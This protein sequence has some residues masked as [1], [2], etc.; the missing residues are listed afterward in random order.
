[1]F[2]FR[3]FSVFFGEV[4][5]GQLVCNGE[6]KASL[7]TSIRGVGRNY[8][9]KLDLAKADKSVLKI[10]DVILSQVDTLPITKLTDN[11][12]NFRFRRSFQLQTSQLKQLET[13]LAAVLPVCKKL[14]LEGDAFRCDMT[15][16][17]IKDLRETIAE[18]R[19]KLTGWS[20]QP[21][22][23]M[24]RLEVTRQLAQSVDSQKD[25]EGV[26]KVIKKSLPLEL[27]YVFNDPNWRKEFCEPRD[28]NVRN[29]LGLVALQLA[30][31]EMTL[32]L[33]VADK[34]T[35]QGVYR[36]SL[37]T[38][39][40]DKEKVKYW[41]RFSPTEETRAN[42]YQSVKLHQ[43][44]KLTYNGIWHPIYGTGCLHLT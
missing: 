26:C 33:D 39:E 42:F 43:A 35:Y 17:S 32:L 41:I 5:V 15:A 6:D 14:Q 21:Y 36:L 38:P 34:E 2:S 12:K 44:E 19:K 25:I 4:K 8:R 7:E 28:E 18:Q 9:V 13:G 31:D 27:P 40:M 10:D 29:H 24:R 3:G 37:E 16:N 30:V 20:R 22:F 11:C 23:L 1:M